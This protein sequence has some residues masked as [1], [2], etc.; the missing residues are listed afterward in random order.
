MF[1]YVALPGRR[2]NAA[3]E[4]ITVRVGC[5]TVMGG[6]PPVGDDEPPQPAR[7]AV[8]NTDHRVLRCITRRLL[9][10]GS[11][12]ETALE[13]SETPFLLLY[14][15]FGKDEQDV[16]LVTAPDQRTE[17]TRMRAGP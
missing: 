3:A 16:G 6:V 15:S 5:G 8:T 14:A 1:L 7:A 9:Y 2:L 12:V 17:T 13:Y 10:D 11:G 4:T